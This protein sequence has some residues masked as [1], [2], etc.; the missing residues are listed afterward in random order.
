M[1][2]LRSWY[3]DGD[4]T[5]TSSLPYL[6]YSLNPRSMCSYAPGTYDFLLE[7]EA[8][9]GWTDGSPYP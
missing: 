7:A 9:D 6:Y 5:T 2:P 8:P 1:E 3:Q 4:Q